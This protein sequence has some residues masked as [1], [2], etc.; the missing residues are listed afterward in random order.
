[1]LIFAGQSDSPRIRG[2]SDDQG[3]QWHLDSFEGIIC[4]LCHKFS[5]LI[6]ASHISGELT[7]ADDGNENRSPSSEDVPEKGNPDRKRVLNILAQ[8]RYRMRP[9]H[10]TM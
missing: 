8:R 1:M 6:I 3:S 10:T 2:V 4:V 5:F 7:M 9:M